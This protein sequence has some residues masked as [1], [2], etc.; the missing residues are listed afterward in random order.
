[1]RMFLAVRVPQ[2]LG[3]YVEL[4][5]S[6]IATATSMRLRVGPQQQ[7]YKLKHMVLLPGLQRLFAP[8]LARLPR[9]CQRSPGA[10]TPLSSHVCP[11]I[12]PVPSYAHAGTDLC[13]CWYQGDVFWDQRKTGG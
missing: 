11:T 2:E 5:R 3:A 1:M 9:L 4:P 10:K 8:L 7:Q 12:S 6:R 13:V